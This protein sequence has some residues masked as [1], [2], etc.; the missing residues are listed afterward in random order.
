MKKSLSRVKKQAK[1]MSIYDKIHICNE[2]MLAPEFSKYFEHQLK[3]NVRGFG[4]WCWKPQI[5]LQCLQSMND[6][7]VL[8]YTDAGCHLNYQGRS[9][10]L[11]YFDLAKVSD[12][13]MVLFRP[14]MEYDAQGPKEVHRNF[15][16][17]YSKSD[18]LDHFNVL[19]DSNVTDSNQFM[20]TAFFIR[21]DAKNIDFIRL[22]IQTFTDDFTLIDDSPSRIDNHKNFVDHRHD[23]SI[24]SV[25]A[26]LK[27]VE[28]ID[29]NE[30][31]TYGDWNELKRFPIWTKRDKHFG[32]INYAKLQ[33]YKIYASVFKKN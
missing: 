12:S 33:L 20:A 3:P 26:K 7:D 1:R 24:F 29:I 2:S 21:K 6:G 14:K 27:K 30:V 15:E 23:Q 28:E 31:F 16:Y 22:W 10:L 9:R 32:F 8:Q 11:E 4:Y 17:M 25:M 19:N 13:G 5:I 18:V